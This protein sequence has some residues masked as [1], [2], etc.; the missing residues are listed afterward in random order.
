MIEGILPN[1]TAKIK[2][3]EEILSTPGA[4]VTE[5]IKKTKTSPNLVVKYTN[6]LVENEVLKESRIGGIKKKH[7]RLLYPNLNQLGIKIFSM[8]EVEKRMRFLKKYPNFRP[9]VSQM[10]DLFENKNIEFA[11]IHGSFARLSADKESDVDLIIVGKADISNQLSDILI[12]LGREYSVKLEIKK[13]FLENMK[14]KS[15]YKNMLK[16]HIIIFGEADFL[17]AVKEFVG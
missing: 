2:I 1:S 10:A 11:L 14:K 16:A 7:V 17:S 9:I 15:V 12:T 6:I 5:I 4:N 13:K 3:L 8:V